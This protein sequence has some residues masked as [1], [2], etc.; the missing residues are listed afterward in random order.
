MLGQGNRTALPICGYFLGSVL[1]DKQFKHYRTKFGKP[2]GIGDAV[3]YNCGGYFKA[4]ADSDSIAVDSLAA[5]PETEMVL[6]ENGNEVIRP[7]EHQEHVTNTAHP[8]AQQAAEEPKQ[9]KI[10]N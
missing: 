5:K 4:P 10:E 1:S 7:K 6:D 9:T 2:E 8:D 3:D